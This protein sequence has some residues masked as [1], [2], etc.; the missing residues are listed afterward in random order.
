[1]VSVY[2]PAEEANAADLPKVLLHAKR[3]HAFR[4]KEPQ[5]DLS[6]LVVWFEPRVLVSAEVGRVKAVWVKTVYLIPCWNLEYRLHKRGQFI[7]QQLHQLQ[8]QKKKLHSVK[9]AYII[10]S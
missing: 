10:P 6:G 9:C 3:K 2:L 5:P 1:M 4:R 8:Q 7:R